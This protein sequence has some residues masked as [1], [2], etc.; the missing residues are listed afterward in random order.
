[1]NSVCVHPDCFSF[2][3]GVVRYRT[4]GV[5]SLKLPWCVCVRACVHMH[6]CNCK[7]IKLGLL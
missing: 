1:V 7:E 4:E 6:L 3:V 2:E 5:L